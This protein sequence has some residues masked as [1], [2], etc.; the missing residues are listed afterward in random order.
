MWLS[1]LAGFSYLWRRYAM[2]A[3]AVRRLEASL[4]EEESAVRREPGW[5]AM[6]MVRAGFRNRRAPMLF[7]LATL[8]GTLAGVAVSFAVVVTGVTDVLSVIFLSL[9]GAV[10]E[11]FLPLVWSLPWVAGLFL[12]GLPALIVQ[13]TRKRRVTHIEQD[14]P[15]L[16]DLLSSLAE[17]G[18]GFDS[19]L[20]RI[21]D[22]QP[23]TR[24]LVQEFR[25]FQTDVLAGRGRIPALRQLGQ[26]VDVTWFSILIAALVHAE[27][28]GS[29]LS[30]TLKIQAED[31]RQRRRERALAFSMAM[32]V[33]LLPALVICFLPGLMV[34]AIA[35]IGYQIVEVLDQFIRQPFGG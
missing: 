6:W 27:Q 18:L 32:P 10:G 23:P 3:A 16:L 28:V 31:L 35:P 22:A 29:G 12:A 33:R 5:F 26:R 20:D 7:L 25:R 15:T 24:P 14:L 30:E 21:L 19:A 8:I 13:S 2:Q 11:V 9:P 34:A 17:A 1:L 4:R